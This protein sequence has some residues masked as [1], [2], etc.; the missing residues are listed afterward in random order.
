MEMQPCIVYV[1]T[2]VTVNKINILGVQQ[3]CF[4]GELKSPTTTHTGLHV[5]CPTF[6]SDF[7]QIWSFSTHFQEA[8]IPNF[9]KISPV[10]TM[11]IHVDRWKGNGNGHFS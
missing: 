6:L 2:H 4:Y 10:G 5:R 8:L 7:N 3:E 11:F 1:E 9:A